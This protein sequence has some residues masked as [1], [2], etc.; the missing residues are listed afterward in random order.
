MK[1]GGLQRILKTRGAQIAVCLAVSCFNKVEKPL[2]CDQ[3]KPDRRKFLCANRRN[4]IKVPVW[5]RT[6]LGTRE[7][8]VVQPERLFGVKI[9]SEKHALQESGGF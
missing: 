5:S 2:A 7:V 1:A 6:V 3:L 8:T 9:P 4:T